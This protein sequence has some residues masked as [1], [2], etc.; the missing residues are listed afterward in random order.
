MQIN[1][2]CILFYLILSFYQ[3]FCLAFLFILLC[4]PDFYF[5]GS[6]SLLFFR[7]YIIFFWQLYKIG[8]V[9]LAGSV[10]ESQGVTFNKGLTSQESN[11]ELR[12]N[13]LTSLP[14]SAYS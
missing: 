14:L 12:I 7:L 9:S 10:R 1:P 11:Q 13:K 4:F 6:G 8:A 2:S 3:E 5:M